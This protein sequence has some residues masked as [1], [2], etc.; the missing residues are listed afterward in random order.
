MFLLNLKI[1]AEKSGFTKIFKFIFKEITADFY[2]EIGVES[3]T[4]VSICSFAETSILMFCLSFETAF[5]HKSLI[6]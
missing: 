3:Q 5:T 6:I 1:D 2:L 4:F